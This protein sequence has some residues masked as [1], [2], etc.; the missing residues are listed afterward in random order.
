MFSKIIFSLSLSVF[1]TN[2]TFLW[3]HSAYVLEFNLAY[4]V[5][6][7][8]NFISTQRI[9]QFF[10]ITGI[11]L[12]RLL[13][14]A[15]MWLLPYTTKK[16]ANYLLTVLPSWCSAFQS[17]SRWAYGLFIFLLILH[18]QLDL[19]DYSMFCFWFL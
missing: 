5:C 17:S 15:V 4:F 13:Y 12:K 14:W 10:L 2:C 7:A 1:T 18:L 19:C 8:A 11:S 3:P 6:G 16:S 9:F